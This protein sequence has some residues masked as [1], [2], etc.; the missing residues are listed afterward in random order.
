MDN[1][2]KQNLLRV[3]RNLIDNKGIEAVSMREVGRSAGL[4]RTASYRHFKNKQSLLAEIVVEDFNI[5]SSIILELEKTPTP[6][7]QFLVK[8]L[9]SYHKFAM[10]NPEHYQLMFNT[11]WDTEIFPEIEAIALLVFQKIA[12]YVEK[13]LKASD[14]TL[15]ASKET[16][17]ILYSF[18]HGL[19]ELNLVGHRET[20]KGL[21][22]PGLLIDKF[23][24]SIF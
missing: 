1:E 9:N 19:V 10:E 6:P 7:K 11:G 4:S 23:I 24:D 17:A 15:H 14:S 20:A 13:A 18:I 21:D 8:A 2:T 5:I 22:N 3:T 12:E 16:T